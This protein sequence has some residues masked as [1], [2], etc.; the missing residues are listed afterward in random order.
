MRVLVATHNYPRFPGDPA[1]AFVRALALGCAEAGHELLV[2]APHAPG[3]AVEERQG[4]VLVRRFRYAPERWERVAY[5]G[6]LHRRP[7]R[8]AADLIAVPGF[9][10]AFGIAIRRATRSW[11]PDV[12][13]AHWWIPGGLAA[14]IAAPGVPLVVTSHGSDVRL[15]RGGVWRRLARAA[16]GGAEVITTVSDHLRGEL[17]RAVPSAA[18]K[19]V[20]APMPVDTDR[21]LAAS[22]TAA[23]HPPRI[24]YAGNLVPTKGVDVLV[25]AFALLRARGIAAGLRILGEGP[26]RAA[27]VRLAESLGVQD[28]VEWSDFVPQD[29]MPAE[30]AAAAVTV[31]PSR[32]GT[33]G[34]GLTLVEALLAGSA[35]IGAR[36]GGIP[37]VVEHGVTGLLVP[38]GDPPA[39]AAALEQLLGDPAA[40]TRLA[41]AGAARMRETY[42]PGPAVARFLGLYHAAIDRARR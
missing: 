12:V 5:T 14:A 17:V 23:A 31:L 25:R 34:L 13:H 4:S 35:V 1:G 21:F 22:S 42:A 40:R 7:L 8:R 6:D 28:S 2:L 38:D 15:L 3:L 16:F 24:L 32:G 26:S 19:T 30:Y 39:L 27:L 29:R 18:G 11:R 9:A 33:E 36:S 20:V 41:A 37:E 10:A